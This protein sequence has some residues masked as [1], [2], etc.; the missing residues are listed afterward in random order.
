MSDLKEIFLEEAG[1]LLAQIEPLVL[2]LEKEMSPELLDELFRV[3][4]TLKGSA[5]IAGIR[6]ISEMTHRLEDLLD[7]LRSGEIE[8]GPGLVDLLL[9]GFDYVKA[10]VTDLAGGQDLPPPEELLE[11]I[12]SYG[13]SE[14]LAACPS[15]KEPGLP[16]RGAAPLAAVLEVAEAQVPEEVKRLLCDELRVGKNVFF[17]TLDFGRN[18]FRQG[19]NLGYLLEDLAGLGT[20]AGLMAD[21]SRVPPLSGLDPE[22]YHLV[23]TLYLA[24]GEGREAVE[25]TFV[26]VNSD[27]N[28]VVVRPV[29]EEELEKELNEVTFAEIQQSSDVLSV[30]GQAP[31]LSGQELLRVLQVLRQQEKA[32]LMAEKEVLPG[33][34]P[35]VR[36][37]MEQIAGRA[38]LA[39]E[40]E[41]ADVPEEERERLIKVAR[42]L[43]AALETETG[44]GPVRFPVAMLPSSGPERAGKASFSSR[45]R[46]VPGEQRWNSVAGEG[47]QVAFKVRRETADALMSLA[48][49]LIIAKNSLPYLVKKLE[50]AG[51]DGQAR[52]LKE[53]FL[54]LDRIAREIHDRVMDIWLLPVQEV[55]GRFPRFVRDQARML[56][57]KVELVTSGGDTRLDRNIIEEIYEPL[58]HLVRNALDH[59]LEEPEERLKA[60]K[61]PVGI[62]QLAACR[63]GERIIIQVTDDG[64]G[65]DVETLAEKAVSGG[66]LSREQ[67]EAMSAREKLKLVFLPGLSSKEGIS[68]LSGRGVGMDVVEKTIS[69]LGGTIQL[70]STPGRGS[71][72]II[73]LPFTLATSEVLMVRIG[74]GVYGIPLA[75]VGET[76]RVEENDIRTVRGRPVAMLRGEIIPLLESRLY[77]ETTASCRDETILVVLRQKAALPVDAVLGKEVVIVKPLTGEL[78][79]LSV[80]MGAAVLGDGRVLLVLDPNEMVR[81]FMNDQG[82]GGILDAGG[83]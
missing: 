72:F 25:E 78:K 53:R 3:V 20:I 83:N 15:E 4:H 61:N 6:G 33:F 48:G 66:I 9:V 23:F 41:P 38:G 52:E 67:V 69:H 35:V 50:A 30:A 55:F 13:R 14:L 76:I 21:Y 82:K 26:F 5:G 12:A 1:E 16:E 65:I 31:P 18:F 62:I 68:D 49:E 34:L 74:G 64:R 43:L 11:E 46:K 58:L 57:K 73:S 75:A 54:Y 42:S 81:L 56:E 40:Q 17:L 80:F 7:G 32:L 10:M 51:L 22:D 19:H 2:E 60:G 39:L 28:R 37:I 77:L 79:R 27:E 47:R 24:T 36:R 71:N 59:G 45:S 70:E 8:A 63:Q 44:A 29:D